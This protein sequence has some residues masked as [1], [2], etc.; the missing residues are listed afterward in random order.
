MEIKV[1]STEGTTR[2]QVIGRVDTTTAADFQQQMEE[3]FAEHPQ[4]LFIDCT[5]LTF[6]SS[7]GLRA[8]FILAKKA[9]AAKVSIFLKHVGDNVREVLRISG[10]DSFFR[11]EE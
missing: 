6:L 4:D 1:I 7:A 2:V 5:E 8:F 3:I 11:L 9:Q 10:F